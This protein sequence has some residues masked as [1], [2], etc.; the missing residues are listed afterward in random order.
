MHSDG[1]GRGVF[2]F[3]VVLCLISIYACSSPLPTGDGERS[4][5]LRHRES[6]C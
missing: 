4:R 3:L 2:S 1:Q 5:R 6:R